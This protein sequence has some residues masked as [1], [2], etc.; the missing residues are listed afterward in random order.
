MPLL[1]MFVGMFAVY[2][3]LTWLTV[4]TAITSYYYVQ[5][6]LK[7]NCQLAVRLFLRLTFLSASAGSSV[8]KVTAQPGCVLAVSYQVLGL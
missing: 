3:V 2:M 4:L 7:G 1:G 5:Q 6:G 8:V